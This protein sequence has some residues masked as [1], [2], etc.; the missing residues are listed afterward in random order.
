MISDAF[1]PA[2]HSADGTSTIELRWAHPTVIEIRWTG[3]ISLDALV[4][5]DALSAMLKSR[6]GPIH[7]LY[8]MLDMTSY[9]RSIV[10][11]HGK[12]S[13]EHDEL[14]RIAV[15]THLARVR[16]AIATVLMLQ[17]RPVR[18]FSDRVS[19]DSWLVDAPARAV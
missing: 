11:P 15:V 2:W 17:K 10:P 6:T 5:F 8:D 19:A 9:D 7:M 12:F 4:Y 18:G 13:A 16:F 1:E 14:G 3:H